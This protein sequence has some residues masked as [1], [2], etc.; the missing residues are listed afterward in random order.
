MREAR[1]I[2]VALCLAAAGA[3]AGSGA[4]QERGS[5]TSPEW[6][7]GMWTGMDGST[8]VEEFWMRPASGVMLGIHRDVDS[9]GFVWFEYLRIET[10][11]GTMVYA[12]M[13]GG[14]PA[15]LFPLKESA[16][17]HMV[18]ENLENDFPQ[19]IIYRLNE[20]GSLLARIEGME[21]GIVK[22]KEWVWRKSVREKN[23]ER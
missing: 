10:R 9:A 11:G 13:P 12:A 14:R 4:R 16:R 5:A 1:W 22:A 21:G 2:I 19:R 15:V 17:N 3:F 23:E 18:F 20:D 7:A 6:L 8:K